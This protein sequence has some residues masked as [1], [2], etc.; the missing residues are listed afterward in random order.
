MR[1]VLVCSVGGSVSEITPQ[2]QVIF[3]YF[4]P[5]EGC[6]CDPTVP[7]DE[8]VKCRHCR[9]AEILSKAGLSPV[10]KKSWWNR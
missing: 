10:E 5:D 8:F 3:D 7:D 4:D 6:D 2:L 1:S 9:A